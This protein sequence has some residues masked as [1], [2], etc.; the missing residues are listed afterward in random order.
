MTHYG[1]L[2]QVALLKFHHSFYN[3]R[4]NT[5]EKILDKQTSVAETKH[6]LAQYVPDKF[7]TLEDF[8]HNICFFSEV[9]K[10][11]LSM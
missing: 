8:W 4:K 3:Y 2:L 10:L 1:P 5:F 9:K 7:Q 11:I 6:K